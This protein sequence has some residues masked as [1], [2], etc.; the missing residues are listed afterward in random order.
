MKKAMGLFIALA[1]MLFATQV[2]AATV[3]PLDKATMLAGAKFDFKVEFDTVVR[4]QDVQVTINGRNYAE[5]LGATGSWMEERLA[6]GSSATALIVRDVALANDNYTVRVKTAGGTD[7]VDWT[8]FP[9]SGQAKA[10]NVIVLIADGLSVGHRTAARLISKGN[11]EGTSQGVLNMDRMERLGMLG[12]SSVDAIT[13]DS[14]NSMSAYMTG[15]KSSINAIG[16]YADRTEDPFD[17][18]KQE[19]IAELL[20]R[21]TGKSIGIV[22][23]AELEDATPAAVVAHT[24]RRAEKAEIVKAFAAIEPEVLLGGGASYFLPQSVT[25]SKR[26]D[27]IDFIKEFS[28]KGYAVVTS[29]TELTSLDKDS[30][31]EKLLGLFHPGNMDG[32]LDRLFLK[33][34]TVPKYPDQPDLTT[35]TKVAL[36]ILSRNDEGFFLMVE[37]GSVDKFAHPMDWERSVYDTIMFDQVVGIAQQFMKSNPDTLLIVTGDHTHSISVY[38]TVDDE[39]EVVA[40][41]R[42]KVGTYANAGFPNYADK[43]G[44][45]YPDD[46]YPTKRLAVGFG[47]HP[48]YYESF[49]PHLEGTFTPA[50]KDENGRY[51][52][53]EAY[54]K[55]GALFMQGNLSYDESQEVHSVD[56]QILSMSGPGSEQVKAYQENTA[57]FRYI[58]EALGID[59]RS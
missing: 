9:P 26:K 7:R 58:V 21:T 51:V 43:N 59:P 29:N 41:I 54:D 5:V 14:A 48:D 42:D 3:Y 44:D 28:R 35:M 18:P 20:R 39:K 4:P 22:S 2:F 25:G 52:A 40:S 31:P 30:M 11:V 50:V 49:A 12:T 47:N 6:D 16:V 27:D 56:D 38:G 13:V 23:D 53:N 33:K 15:H 36:D 32:A 57:T 46:V 34:N 37:A 1:V 8:V 45:G 19:N 10:K 24:R 55:D 17:D